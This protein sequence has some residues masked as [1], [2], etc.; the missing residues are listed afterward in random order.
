[1]MLTKKVEHYSGA[2]LQH[3]CNGECPQPTELMNG[4]QQTSSRKEE[5][6]RLCTEADV[7]FRQKTTGLEQYDFDYVALPELDFEQIATTTNFLGKRLDAPLLISSMTG[8]YDGATAINAALA[9][10]CQQRRL[11][12]GLG[13]MRQ[14]LESHTHRESF[15]IVRKIAPDIPLIAN[16][17]AT[18]LV[19]GVAPRQVERLVTMISA[20]AIAVHLNPLQELLQPEGTPRFHGVLAAIAEL[21]ATLPVPVIVKEVGAGISGRVAEQ[22]IS[23]GVQIVDVAGAGGTSWAGVELLRTHTAQHPL[24]ELWDCGIPTADCIVEVAALRKQV[25]LVII[26]SGGIVNGFDAA[27]A[28]ALGADLV[29]IARPVLQALQRGETELNRYLDEWELQLRAA[30]FITGSATI[31]ALGS[32]RLRRRS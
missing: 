26:G 30:M 13:S 2:N 28:I 7:R 5:H 1:M 25:P 17:G 20:D 9:R 29:G 27:K 8:G 4:A 19:Q 24:T 15:A 11:A 14:A 18:Q 32:A 22:L 21:I 3:I 31:A 10:V 16:I 6:V 23:I 12:L